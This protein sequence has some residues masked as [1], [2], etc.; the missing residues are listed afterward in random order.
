MKH[1]RVL[2]PQSAEDG[3]KLLQNIAQRA[4]YC[5]WF[6]WEGVLTSTGNMFLYKTAKINQVGGKIS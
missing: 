3:R 5:Y 2:R 1:T 4:P 6:F